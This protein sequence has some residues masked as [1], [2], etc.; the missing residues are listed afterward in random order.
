L[1]HGA[2]HIWR[3]ITMKLPHLDTPRPYFP[4]SPAAQGKIH[5]L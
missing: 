4:A 1:V 3:K 5:S 2:D